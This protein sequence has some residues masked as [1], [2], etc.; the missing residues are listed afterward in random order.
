NDNS[1]GVNAVGWGAGGHK[2]SDLVGTDHAGFQLKD[3]SGVVR[4]S[5]NIDYLS[6][7][8]A[9]P[10]GYASL[11][12]FGGDGQVL[13]GT[14]TPNDITCATSIDRTLKNVNIPV[15]FNA[16]HLQQIGSV[17]V[18]VNSPPTDGQ[19]LTYAISDPLLAGWDF[20]DTYYVTITAAK[21]QSL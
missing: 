4:L 20:H 10:S 15:L 16:Q 3:P 5:F 19:H 13:A 11:G 1:Y 2:Y 21:L 8:L 18:L 9:A 17:N 14:L 12:P 7:N 6:A